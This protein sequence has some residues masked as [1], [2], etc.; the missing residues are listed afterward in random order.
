MRNHDVAKAEVGTLLRLERFRGLCHGL[1]P[2]D[3]GSPQWI[4]QMTCHALHR[5]GDLDWAES[6]TAMTLQT[7]RPG[8][9]F[10][11]Q[12]T[13]HVDSIAGLKPLLQAD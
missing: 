11:L 6:D 10:S 3:G 1:E 5:G 13:G 7:L 2:P 8:V 12:A 9:R 4:D